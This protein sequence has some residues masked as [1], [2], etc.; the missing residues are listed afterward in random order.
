MCRGFVTL[1]NIFHTDDQFVGTGHQKAQERES[2]GSAF[3][4]EA[5][6]RGT[7]FIEID[8]SVCDYMTRQSDACVKQMFGRMVKGDGEIN[9]IFPFQTLE[10]SF[11]IGDLWGNQFDAQ[12]E[13]ESNQNLRVS[14]GV[15]ARER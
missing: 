2:G 14:N 12:K 3:K 13:K 9:A 15:S 11:M 7:P 5:D 1:G 10:H 4:R 6:E 8:Q